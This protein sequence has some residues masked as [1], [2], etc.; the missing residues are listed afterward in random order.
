MTCKLDENCVFSDQQ[1]VCDRAAVCCTEKLAKKD[2][3]IALLKKQ[4][5]YLG[6]IIAARDED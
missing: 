3:K 6:N 5:K 1:P 4:I 2:K